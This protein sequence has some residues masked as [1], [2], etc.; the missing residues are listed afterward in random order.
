MSTFVQA[1]D[2]LL[3]VMSISLLLCFV[4]LYLGPSVPDRNV[5][6]DLITV[7]AMGLFGLVA[8]RA[9][10]PSLLDGAII[11]AVLGFLGTV[12]LARYLESSK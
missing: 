2:I 10:A 12:M 5:A 9:D 3:V 4:R 11:T 6:F 1:L 7:H 8:M